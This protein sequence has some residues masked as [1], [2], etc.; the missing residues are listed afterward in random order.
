MRQIW[1]VFSLGALV[2]CSSTVP[3]APQRSPH[4][5]PVSAN[6]QLGGTVYAYFD[7]DGDAERAADFFIS[8]L[9]DLPA[10]EAPG[11]S[12]PLN[13]TS[14]VRVLGLDNVHAVG[15]SSYKK[16]PLYHNRSF[17]YHTGPREGLLKVFG[18]EPA[19]LGLKAIAPEGADLVWEQQLNLKV[20]VD[21]ARALGERGVGVSPERL[22][23]T[24]AESLLGLDITI[25]EIVERLDTT[26][27]LILEVD[28][29]RVLRIPGESFWFPYT[30]FLFQI[31]GLGD[32]VDAIAKRATFDPFIR[33]DRTDQWLTIRPGIRLPPPWNAYEPSLIKDL[34]TGRMY[35]VSK[36]D[37]LKKC[38]SQQSH[39]TATA[40]FVTAFDGLPTIGNGMVFISPQLTRE[41]HAMLDRVIND[42]GSTIFTT[43]ARVLLPDAG[44]P[45]GWV[46]AN[47]SDGILFT[48]NSSSSHKSTLITLGF[49]ALLPAVAVLGASRLEPSPEAPEMPFR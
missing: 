11:A 38:L 7:I 23:E 6:L 20:L 30:D 47:R 8:L 10:L 2:A 42:N 40:D 19:E 49:A 22:D 13:A 37:Y 44:F 3:M 24:L 12:Q 29:A 25:G 18:G 31:D 36:P 21:I 33:A 1:V 15:L 48:S 9:R 26:A 5:D 14:L 16:E 46:G 28:E 27:G 43:I 17:I 32:L 45:I 39:V 41:M 4:F 35:V 34:A